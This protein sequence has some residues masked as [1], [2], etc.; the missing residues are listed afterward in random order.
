MSKFYT[1]IWN[2]IATSEQRVVNDLCE[3]PFIF[4]PHISG[5][6][7]E[8]AVSGVFLSRK[9]VYWHDSTGFTDQMKVVHPEHVTGLTQCPVA[10][11]LCGV[12]PSLHDFF[13]NI[14]GVDEF[15]PFHGYLQILMQLSAVALP[16]EAAKTVSD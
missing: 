10:K 6:W 11:M 13:V 3:G 4:V 2:R 15:P 7:P 9:E 1:F 16:S 5:S 14:C 12:Y 8:D